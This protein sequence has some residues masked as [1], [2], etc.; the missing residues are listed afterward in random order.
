MSNIEEMKAMELSAEE[1]EQ[2]AGGKYPVLPAK[3]GYIV[4]QIQTGDT[5]YKLAKAN[6]TTVDKLMACN[7]Q[8]TDR[9]LIRAGAYMYI[10]KK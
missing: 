2:A 4:Y 7:P 5:L 9:N 1:L 8:I 6:H 3:K 10:P